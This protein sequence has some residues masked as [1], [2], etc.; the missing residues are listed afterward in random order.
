MPGGYI[1]ILGS[2]RGTLY[3]GVT[4]VRAEQIAVYVRGTR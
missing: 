4:S 2:H 3:I 1:Y